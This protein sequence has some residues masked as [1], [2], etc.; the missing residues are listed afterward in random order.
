M[1]TFPYDV[2]TPTVDNPVLAGLF[3]P[4]SAD[5]VLRAAFAEADRRRAP[6]TV[7]IAAPAAVDTGLPDA[8]ERWAEKYPAVALTVSK[9]SAVD[10]AI[11]VTAAT[12]GCCLAV[13]PAPV[14]TL[15][16]ALVSAVTRRSRCPVL[17]AGR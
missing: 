7:L 8:I 14:T 2:S 10:P 1:T 3:S 5:D 6:L 16:S 17:T 12:G 9:S 15:E 4:A 11:F 13:L